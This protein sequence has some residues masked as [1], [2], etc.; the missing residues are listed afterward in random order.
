[1]KVV[2]FILR[3]VSIAILTWYVLII[4]SC[5]PQKEYKSKVV[6]IGGCDHYGKCG[7]RLEDGTVLSDVRMPVIGSPPICNHNSYCYEVAH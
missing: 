6:N 4:T 2:M 7:V 3:F 1:M 5:A